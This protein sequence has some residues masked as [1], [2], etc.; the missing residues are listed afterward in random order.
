MLCI[1][2]TRNRA[3]V[4]NPGTYRPISHWRESGTTPSTRLTNSRNHTVGYDS[5]AKI[6][7]ASKASCFMT[8]ISSKAIF[9]CQPT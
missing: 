9:E 1:E 3:Y 6:F 7:G 5:G 4:E 8:I 2:Q